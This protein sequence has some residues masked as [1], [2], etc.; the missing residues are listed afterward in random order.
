MTE[1]LFLQLYEARKPF[2][3]IDTRERCE[4]IEG[5][6]LG[7][8]NIPLSDF[9]SRLPH[10]I[11]S[12]DFPIHLLSWSSKLQKISI[13]GLTELGYTN[14]ITHPTCRPR[15]GTSGFLQGEHSWSKAF[16][17]VLYRN[18]NF[19]EIGPEEYIKNRKKYTLYD[20][21]PTSEYKLFT[22]PNSINLPNSNLLSLLLNLQE[23]DDFPV[24]HCAGRTRSII[25]ACTLMAAGYPSRFCVF[26]G[27][28]Q[29][30]ELSGKTR[31]T[32]AN[33][34]MVPR[35]ENLSQ[36]KGLV[37][38]WGIKISTVEKEKIS[39]RVNQKKDHLF[40]DVSDDAAETKPSIHPIKKI[41]GT[42]MVQQTDVA[43]ACFHVPITLFDSGNG[44]RAAFAAL[45]LKAMG[46][47]VEILVS[48]KC[49]NSGKTERSKNEE[50]NNFKNWLNFDLPIYDFRSSQDFQNCS[51]RGSVWANLA[52]F[53]IENDAPL[54]LGA[55]CYNEQHFRFIKKLLGIYGLKVKSTVCWNSKTQIFFNT[56]KSKLEAP[57][58]RGKMY[59]DRHKGNLEDARGY[60]EW[61]E[62]LPEKID[63]DIYSMWSKNIT[64]RLR[65]KV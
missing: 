17:E 47:N 46:Y 33:R 26:K 57:C 64:S 15:D 10:L 23:K 48:Q 37:K 58:D 20:V 51:I 41:S 62:T 7:S 59:A 50:F 3:L 25:G 19:I 21:R 6:W 12:R 56:L 28:T 30:W 65:R 36:I 53:L 61:E 43:I 1:G 35:A 18:T 34:V 54:N 49:L 16:G 45:W 8:V 60:L 55:V 63:A 4:F 44:C 5:H 2:S 9:W 13:A 22:L 14:I 11:R 38:R 39:E 42:N 27:G 31:E 29:A 52:S 32:N 24:L 40:F